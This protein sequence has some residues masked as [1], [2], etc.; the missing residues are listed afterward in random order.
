MVLGVVASYEIAAASVFVVSPAV[1][2]ARITGAGRGL[3]YEFE[4]GGGRA[5]YERFL[6]RPTVPPAASGVTVGIGFD[7]GYNSRAQILRA[8]GRL[9]DV[10]PRLAEAAGLTRERARGILPGLRDIQIAWGDAEA[11]FNETTLTDFLEIADVAFPGMRALVPDAQ[12]VLVSLVFNRGGSMLGDS[13]REMRAIRSLVP[14]AD[15]RAMAR[16]IRAM[17][18]LW[19]DVPGLQR[20]REA[21]A[22][23]MEGCA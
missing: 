15:Y 2:D 1:P 20:R 6:A 8:W 5:Y 17:K 23:M 11:V 14:R 21:E 3:I 18:R 7:C 22:R 16:E 12:A 4:V 13:R 9:P 10:A 19:P